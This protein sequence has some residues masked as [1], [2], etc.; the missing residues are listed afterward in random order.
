MVVVILSFIGWPGM[1]RVI[2]GMVLSL[3]QKEFVEAAKAMG[4]PSL[5]II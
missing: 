1:S 5:H 4:Y 2:R 3:K